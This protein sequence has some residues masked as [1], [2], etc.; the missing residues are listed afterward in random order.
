MTVQKGKLAASA[1]MDNKEVTVMYTNCQPTST[2]TVPRRQKDGSR[3]QIPCPEAIINYNHF[4]GGVDRRDQCRGYYSCRTKSRKFY[5]YI[6]FFL[7]DVCITNAYIIYKHHSSPVVHK[8]IKDFRLQ[9]A[10]ELIA[11]Y[12]TRRRPGRG[13]GVLRSIPLRHF[14]TTIAVDGATHHKRGRCVECKAKR[15]RKD[16]TWYCQ[17]C[18]AWLCHNGDPNHD[19]FLHYHRNIVQN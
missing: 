7:Y 13:G 15:I 12:C 14:P 2:G 5:K 1:W 16:T 10:H 11:D 18:R 9:L 6:F 3:R 8:N 19:C 4:M 17:E